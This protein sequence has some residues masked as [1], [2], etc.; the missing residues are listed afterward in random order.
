MR[1]MRFRE[2]ELSGAFVI[3]LERHTDERGFFARTFC[4]RELA[5]HG[6]PTRFPQCNLS[7]NGKRGTLRG[8]HYSVKPHPEA[9]LVR[10]TRG[11]IYDVIVDLRP[12]SATRG[13]WIAVELSAEAGNALFIPVGFGHGFLTLADET[14]VFYHMGEFFH[15]ESQRGFRHDD[16]AYGIRWPSAPSVISERDANYPL[17]DGGVAD[18]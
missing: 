6:L 17:L 5:A 10:C 8:M 9:K 2:T 11:A 15:A 4:E 1:A 7:Y 14:D 18:V 3:E 16:P 13:R 12:G